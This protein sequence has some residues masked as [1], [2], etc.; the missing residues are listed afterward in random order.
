MLLSAALVLGATLHP[1]RLGLAGCALEPGH[2]HDDGSLWDTDTLPSIYQDGTMHKAEWQD[3]PRKEGGGNTS[4]VS[5]RP[6]TTNQWCAT[7][8]SSANPHAPDGSPASCPEAMC[9][10][11]A[12]ARKQLQDESNEVL[13][14]WKEAESRVRG[15]KANTAYPD[16]LPPTDLDGDDPSLPQLPRAPPPLPASSIHS[17]NPAPTP[18][19]HLPTRATLTALPPP[20][21]A[22]V[23]I[24][25]AR[26]DKPETCRSI[27][28]PATDKWCRSECA[29]IECPADTCECDDYNARTREEERKSGTAPKTGMESWRE[30]EAASRATDA[31]ARYP[32]G[33]APV[34]S[35]APEWVPAKPVQR[36]AASKD[37]KSCKATKEQVS[38]AWCGMMCATEECPADM[39]KCADAAQEQVK[40]QPADTDADAPLPAGLDP[41]GPQ[42][43]AMDWP[44]VSGKTSTPAAKKTAKDAEPRVQALDPYWAETAGAKEAPVPAGLTEAPKQDLDVGVPMGLRDGEEPPKQALDVGVPVGLGDDQEPPKM[45]LDPYWA[46][47]ASASATTTADESAPAVAKQATD[48]SCKSQVPSTNDFWC[49]TQCATDKS[50]VACPPTICKCGSRA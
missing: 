39:C 34:V 33:L 35:P 23:A 42:P 40:L 31:A 38:D 36:A 14:N 5:I 24:Q 46:A 49:A 21:H 25:K 7:M 1:C 50:S 44:S 17:H 6:G 12:E 32:D 15:V 10:C 8:C 11:T 43:A 45:A 22:E 37:P 4:C 18:Q 19:T 41:D 30:S 13:A 26:S 47:P 9:S 48:D 3:D 29:G 27:K 2:K 16:G 28:L 20:R